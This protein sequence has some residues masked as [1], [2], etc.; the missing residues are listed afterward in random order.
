[1]E[2]CAG[3]DG[4]RWEEGTEGPLVLRFTDDG[5]GFGVEAAEDTEKKQFF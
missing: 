5:S 4:G 2:L 3:S 1:M